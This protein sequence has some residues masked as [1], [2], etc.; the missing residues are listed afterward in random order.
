[1]RL[2]TLFSAG[3][4]LLLSVLSFAQSNPRYIQF[5][6]PNVKGALY[7]PDSVP[8]PHV[9]ILVIH[10][11]ANFMSHPATTELSK[12]GFLVLG[13]NPRSDNNETVVDFEANALDIKAGLE[14]LRKQ[15][16]ITK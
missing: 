13:M 16:G 4:L 14:F 8:A 12:R 11:T 2:R 10:R 1:M 7:K 6:P 5:R 9:A 3:L 15:P